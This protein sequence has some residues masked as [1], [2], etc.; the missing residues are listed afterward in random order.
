MFTLLSILFCTA[1]T[2]QDQ[3]IL[4]DGGDIEAQVTEITPEYIKY[5][6]FD[7]LDG[8]TITIKK[9]SVFLIRYENGR[10]EVINALPAPAEPA[11][12]TP[13]AP[14]VSTGIPEKDPETVAQ[15]LSP[16]A[17]QTAL[18]TT[19]PIAE[20]S[21]ATMHSVSE[22]F[23]PPNDEF[24][25][26]GGLALPL[27]GGYY[28]IGFY[29]GLERTW[30][31]AKGLGLLGHLSGSYNAWGGY[32]SYG[33]G[34]GMIN[35][36]LG[37]GLQ[38]RAQKGAVQPYGMLLFGTTFIAY[39]GTDLSSEWALTAGAGVGLLINGQIDIGARFQYDIEN[40]YPILQ[41]GAG[42]RF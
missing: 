3:I 10:K 38:A 37:S 35:V 23:A 22:R 40:E 34:S 30:Y 9:E 13:P 36:F 29:L 4:V 17:P 28:D 25:L 39:P 21:A 1:L 15:Q 32:D 18:P 20:E 26:L 31:F 2:A 27:D 24:A 8:P 12:V 16:A 33:D 7:H 6:R 42:Y 19:A 5:K 41:V 14:P 11:M